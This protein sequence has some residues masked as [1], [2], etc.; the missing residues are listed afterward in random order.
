MEDFIKM[1]LH[2][3]KIDDC[4]EDIDTKNDANKQ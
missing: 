2:E 4:D 1:H 3:C